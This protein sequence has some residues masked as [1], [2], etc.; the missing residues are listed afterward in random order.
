MQYTLWFMPSNNKSIT[1]ALLGCYQQ[2]EVHCL[3]QQRQDFNEKQLQ[4]ATECR[5]EFALAC[6][7]IALISP[8]PP[9]FQPFMTVK[10]WQ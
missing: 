10:D 5:L 7:S 3:F 1:V 6:F 4:N 9:I 8:P 2:R